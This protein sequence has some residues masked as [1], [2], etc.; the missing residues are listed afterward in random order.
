MH[1]GNPGGFVP[2]NGF[3][4]VTA[5]GDKI[6][7]VSKHFEGDTQVHTDS[8]NR[9]WAMHFDGLRL[10]VE[11]TVTETT[12]APA[13]EVEPP[14]AD[15]GAA[16]F[17]EGAAA[18]VSGD[19]TEVTETDDTGTPTKDEL[20]AGLDPLPGENV[21]ENTPEPA[22]DVPPEVH[23]DNEVAPVTEAVAPIYTEATDDPENEAVIPAEPADPVADA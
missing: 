15:E 20:L 22:A 17:L 16:A 23:P 10:V 12:E 2:T 19:V 1:P 21:V 8:F 9:K 5:E 7:I 18:A 4:A 6:T 14:P 13:A 3:P 11:E